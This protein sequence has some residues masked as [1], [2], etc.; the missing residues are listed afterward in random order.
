M[1]MHTSI[2]TE[3]IYKQNSVNAPQE[4]DNKSKKWKFDDLV[5]HNKTKNAKIA[6][7]P[8]NTPNIPF[9]EEEEYQLWN[10]D[11]ED[12]HPSGF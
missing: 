7:S 12:E 4:S 6:Q 8:V 11:P 5:R 3:G 2:Y 9:S 10:Y 1:K